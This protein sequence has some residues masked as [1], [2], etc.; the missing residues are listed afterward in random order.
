[1]KENRGQT[2]I[3]IIMFLVFSSLAKRWTCGMLYFLTFCVR[4]RRSPIRVTFAGCLCWLTFC[5]CVCGARCFTL[6]FCAN[7]FFFLF[8]CVCRQRTADTSTIFSPCP[9]FAWFETQQTIKILMNNANTTYLRFD[10]RQPGP[11]FPCCPRNNSYT[12]L[13]LR[14]PR[15]FIDCVLCPCVCVS[16]PKVTCAHFRPWDEWILQTHTSSRYQQYNG[17]I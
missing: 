17:L 11:F 16:D 12:R 10:L 6:S 13:G 4:P 8:L 9:L 7:D 1:M 14:W 5:V 2:L 3:I 15:P